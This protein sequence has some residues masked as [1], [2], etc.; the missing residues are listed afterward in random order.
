MQKEIENLE[1][2]HGV[3]FEI[4]DLSKNNGTKYLSVFDNSCEEICNSKTFVDF[5]TVGRHRGLNTIYIKHN[6]LYQSKL[7]RKVELQSALFVL[8]KCPCDVMHVSTLIAQLVL[9]SQQ[10]DWFEEATSVPY[11]HLL[12]DLS[13]RTGDRFRYPLNT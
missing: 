12:V 4:I 8:F 10:V 9:R 1:F 7:R 11:G 2:V 13:P 5:A 3:H 6:L